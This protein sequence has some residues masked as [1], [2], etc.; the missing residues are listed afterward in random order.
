MSDPD[1]RDSVGADPVAITD[2]AGSLASIASEIRERFV[3]MSTDAERTVAEHWSGAAAD[4][5]LSS[6]SSVRN[7]GGVLVDRLYS[8]VDGLEASSTGYR[9]TDSVNATT[10]SILNLD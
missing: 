9:S 1:G 6:W 3:A 4:D 7:R 8:L 10:T 2:A 5:Y